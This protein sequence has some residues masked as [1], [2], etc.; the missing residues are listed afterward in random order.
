MLFSG[1]PDY[2]LTK[3][4]IK[5][6]N[7]QIDENLWNV[8]CTVKK[9]SGWVSKWLEFYFLDLAEIQHPERQGFR[10]F[11]RWIEADANYQQAV[12]VV[13]KDFP[14]LYA[15]VHKIEVTLR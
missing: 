11:G 10:E 12:E 3:K 8:L 14:Q 7:P 2:L 9:T 5:K 4:Q 6:Q 1:K 13:Q 15:L